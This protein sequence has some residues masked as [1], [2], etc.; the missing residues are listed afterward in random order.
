MVPEGLGGG[1]NDRNKEAAII[2]ESNTTAIVDFSK[3]KKI[4]VPDCDL[5]DL[6]QFALQH[7]G[8]KRKRGVRNHLN[9]QIIV[10]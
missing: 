5:K 6:I 8:L 4:C 2:S 1:L 10:D 3:K 9:P 7:C